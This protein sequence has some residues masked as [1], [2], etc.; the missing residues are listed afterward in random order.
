[1]LAT[2]LQGKS[3]KDL[4]DLLLLNIKSYKFDDEV[5]LSGFEVIYEIFGETGS[6]FLE[7]QVFWQMILHGM[8]GIDIEIINT[9]IEEIGIF[10]FIAFC[11][12][13]LGDKK[14][15]QLY[16]SMY[17]QYRNKKESVSTIITS[18]LSAFVEDL[19]DIQPEEINKIISELNLNL[20]Q[21]P[22]FIK[23]AVK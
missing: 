13:H 16:D 14:E 22:D 18:V 7:R 3:K 11:E 2:D 4:Q 23:N 15:T 17:T 1:M 6:F 10:E 20:D 9:L 8:F 5:L 19:G 21:L 12:E